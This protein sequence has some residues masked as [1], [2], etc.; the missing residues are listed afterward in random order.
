MA[1]QIELVPGLRCDP[2]TTEPTPPSELR[3]KPEL[4]SPAG[5]R[6]CL[7]AAV[8]N[9]ADAV[10]FGLRRHNARIRAMNFDGA[11]LAE[12]MALLASSGRQGICHAQYPGLSRT[13]WPTSRPRSASWSRRASMR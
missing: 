13:S 2:S 3:L 4:L 11:D 8:E 6:T 1:N 10:Y 5:D 12:V 7:L 9:G